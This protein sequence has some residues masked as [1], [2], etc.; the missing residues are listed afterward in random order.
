MHP[1]SAA[2]GPTRGR[3][4]QV[5]PEGVAGS[6]G[7]ARAW[8]R[9]A[10]SWSLPF[11]LVALPDGIVGRVWRRTAGLNRAFAAEVRTTATGCYAKHSYM[12]P[13]LTASPLQS[14]RSLCLKRHG[15]AATQVPCR[16]VAQLV[17]YRS[18]KPVVA[19]SSP[20]APAN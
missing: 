9:F 17:E 15:S 14:R 18:P 20:A 13:R 1:T 4:I 10:G 8:R 16:G 12:V 19:G 2:T 3:A 5:W 11:A 7:R 6:E